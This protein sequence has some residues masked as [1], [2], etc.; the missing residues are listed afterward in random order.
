MI[1]PI[2]IVD[3][4]A[5]SPVCEIAAGARA[6][7]VPASDWSCIN[8]QQSVKHQSKSCRQ[9]IYYSSLLPDQYGGAKISCQYSACWSDAKRTSESKTF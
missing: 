2:N 6:A 7:H 5:D 3:V 9:H 4:I 1:F 8:R